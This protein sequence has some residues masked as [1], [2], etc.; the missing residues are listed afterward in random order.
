MTPR[1]FWGLYAL[2]LL[3][4][5]LVCCS[6][7]RAQTTYPDATPHHTLTLHVAT[8]HASRALG[9][10]ANPGVGF[11][12]RSGWVAG[13]YANSVGRPTVYAGYAPQ[14]GRW[15]LAFLLATGYQRDPGQ[16]ERRNL[17]DGRRVSP[18]LV[19]SVTLGVVRLSAPNLQGVHLS[20][21]F[22]F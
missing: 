9:A 8:A 5:L 18:L 6:D 15:G 1:S 11:R 4:A 21:D 20:L 2:G 7:L 3:L 17:L 13:A 10:T 22:H 14:W 12:H 19:P 16:H